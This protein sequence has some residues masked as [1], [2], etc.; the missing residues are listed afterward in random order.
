MSYCRPGFRES[1]FQP[2][3][4]EEHGADP[5]PDGQAETAVE[6]VKACNEQEDSD[7]DETVDIERI[8]DKEEDT[9]QVRSPLVCGTEDC[10]QALSTG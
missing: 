4:K 5:R 6:D 9:A 2:F 8:E 7:G 10:P 1:A 3:N